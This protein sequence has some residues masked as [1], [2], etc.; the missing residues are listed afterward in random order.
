MIN[1]FFIFKKEYKMSVF[2]YKV[3]PIF[4]SDPRELTTK[5]Q[6]SV[7]MNITTHIKTLDM[8]I[9]NFEWKLLVYQYACIFPFY[10]QLY[11]FALRFL[12]RKGYS[13]YLA[14]GKLLEIQEPEMS[15]RDAYC[16]HPL[17]DLLCALY[18][19]SFFSSYI[20]GCAA[21]RN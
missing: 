8:L 18:V 5:Y 11:Y 21:T 2:I 10:E 4:S 15:K 16:N 14:E 19:E 7:P 3:A 20:L 9:I 12:R 17:L 13:Q 1:A 6:Y